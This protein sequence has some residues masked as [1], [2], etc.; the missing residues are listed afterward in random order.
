MIKADPPFRSPR[1]TF[2]MKKLILPIL[3]LPRD[4]STNL[5]QFLL[6]ISRGCTETRFLHVSPA[7]GP[8]CIW[9]NQ[10][11]GNLLLAFEVVVFLTLLLDFPTSFLSIP[12]TMPSQDRDF[13]FVFVPFFL[14]VFFF[15]GDCLYYFTYT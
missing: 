1:P 14:S 2:Q 9:Y 11:P 8:P 3:Q 12:P 6:R 13:A 7:V 4:R 15:G 10:P 5:N